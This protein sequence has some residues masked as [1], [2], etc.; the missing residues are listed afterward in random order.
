MVVVEVATV[1]M[2]TREPES[3]HRGPRTY[4]A[5]WVGLHGMGFRKS[6]TEGFLNNGIWHV[7]VARRTV[8]LKG[9]M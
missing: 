4:S 2:P 7:G 8:I 3:M 1:F 6:R 9:L 5:F